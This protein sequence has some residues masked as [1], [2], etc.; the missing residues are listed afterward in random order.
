MTH[1]VIWGEVGQND[2]HRIK[3]I[4]KNIAV[5][6]AQKLWNGFCLPKKA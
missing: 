3:N 5:L 6:A 4:K 2:P 1:L